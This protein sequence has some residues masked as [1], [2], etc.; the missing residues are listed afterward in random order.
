ML[1]LATYNDLW[2]LFFGVFLQRSSNRL[3]FGQE[4]SRKNK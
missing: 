3:L 4:L 1:L 2:A